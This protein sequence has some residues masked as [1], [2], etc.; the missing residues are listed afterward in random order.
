MKFYKYLLL[1]SRPAVLMVSCKKSDFVAVNINPSILPTVDPG[2][3]FLMASDHLVKDFE[4]FY[5]FNRAINY[6]MQY[7]TGNTGKSPSFAIPGG[8]FNYRYDNFYTNVGIPLA[9][10]PHLIAKMSPEQQAARVYELN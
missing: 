4:H 10:I 1:F 7:T 6:W 8:N 3:Q 5:D 2:A 9:D